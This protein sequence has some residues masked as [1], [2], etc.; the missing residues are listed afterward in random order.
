M[1]DN[2]CAECGMP[3]STNEYHPFAACLMFKACHN[4][5]TVKV[6]LDAVLAQGRAD[7]HKEVNDEYER[8]RRNATDR[9]I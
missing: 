8:T 7:M 9:R 5:E 4:S 3:V 6:N 1:T 2:T